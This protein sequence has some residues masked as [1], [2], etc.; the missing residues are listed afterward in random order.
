MTCRENIHS[1]GSE[2]DFENNDT[3]KS[4]SS[5]AFL[6][7]VAFANV[8]VVGAEA[9]LPELNQSKAFL[10]AHCVSCHGNDKSEA[11]LIKSGRSLPIDRYRRIM[12]CRTPVWG[13]NGSG[14]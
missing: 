5:I 3:M 10:T 4:L 9:D 2:R 13:W 11:M 6:L 14:F 12:N 1:T 7:V 8:T